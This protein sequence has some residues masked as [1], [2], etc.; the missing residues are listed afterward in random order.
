MTQQRDA[1]RHDTT[2]PNPNLSTQHQ[3]PGD[4]K[5]P[6]ETLDRDQPPPMDDGGRKSSLTKND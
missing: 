1:D 2:Q 3:R 6:A 4:A 5:R